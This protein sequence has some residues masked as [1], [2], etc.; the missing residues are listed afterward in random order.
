MELTILR[1]VK[2]YNPD[3]VDKKIASMQAE[4]DELTYNLQEDIQCLKEDKEEMQ[5]ESDGLIREN[6]QLAKRVVQQES[7]MA[8]MQTEIDELKEL[9]FEVC[10]KEFVTFEFIR[11]V[12][13]IA[14][15]EQEKE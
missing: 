8:T 14:K 11:K 5:I 7:E 3:D 10:E 15:H 4:I 13:L 9:L 12:Q 1:G 2:I 6:V